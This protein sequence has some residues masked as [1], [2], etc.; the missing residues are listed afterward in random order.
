MHIFS[1]GN[2]SLKVE[3]PTNTLIVSK[4]QGLDS[5]YLVSDNQYLLSCKE[6]KGNPEA[7]TLNID[8][9]NGTRMIEIIGSLIY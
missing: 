8:F 3:L 6:I 1:R 4:K 9:E 5:P 2:G 7:R